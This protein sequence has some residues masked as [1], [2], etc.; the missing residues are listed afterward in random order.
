VS[1]VIRLTAAG[2]LLGGFLLLPPSVHAQAAALVSQSSSALR[3]PDALLERVIRVD[4]SDASIPDAADIIAGNAGARISYSRELLGNRRVSLHRRAITVGA[5]LAEILGDSGLEPSVS[6]GDFI[7]IEPR[8][9]ASSGL[10][11][12]LVVDEAGTPLDGASILVG[13]NVARVTDYGG[14]FSGLRLPAGTGVILVRKIGYVARAIPVPDDSSARI[15]LRIALAVAPLDLDRIVV[16]GALSGSAAQS[17][18]STVTVLSGT[19]LQAMQLRTIDDLFRGFVPGVVGWDDG[20]S[21]LTSNLGSVRG[22]ASFSVNYFKTYVDGVE[23][24]APFL[25]SMIDPST[26]DR[27]EIIRGPQGAALHGSD[28]SS[29]VIQIVTRDGRGSV[30]GRPHLEM[31]VGEGT[32]QSRFVP[33]APRTQELSGSMG[34]ANENASFLFGGKRQTTGEFVKGASAKQSSAYAKLH[35]GTGTANVD[36]EVQQND[37]DGGGAINPILAKIGI[38]ILHATDPVRVAHHRTAGGT[39]HLAPSSHVNFLATAGYDRSSLAGVGTPVPFISP[40]DSVLLASRGSAER[41]SIRLATDITLGAL[42]IVGSSLSLGFD[43]SRL[44]HASDALYNETRLVSPASVEFESSHGLFSQANLSLAE[45]VFLTAGLR[46]EWNSSFGTAYGST[47]LPLLGLSVVRDIG[48]VTLKTRSSY[49]K[50]IRPPPIDA[51]R[52]VQLTEVTQ[53]ANPLL[54]PESQSGT[55]LGLDAYFDKWASLKLTHYDQQAEGLIQQ[56]LVDGTSLPR[57]VQQQNIGTIRNAG[58]ELEA[59]G[60]IGWLGLLAN[61]ARTESRVRSIAP[62][63]T[64]TLR[65]GDRMLEVPSWTAS[66]TTTAGSSDRSLSLTVWRVGD[67]INYDWISL[68]TAVLKQ[69]PNRGPPRSYWIRYP[70]FTQIRASARKKIWRSSEMFIRGDNLSNVQNAGRDNLHVNTGRTLTLGVNA[71]Y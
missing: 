26:V 54:A 42:G 44:K 12:G 11:S 13:G 62:R 36:L 15:H 24:A 9:N 65:P 43:A 38:P 50:G 17:L 8:S 34:G 49:G 45:T 18:P 27:I 47:Q 14:L 23:V 40:A 16:M 29:G 64:G 37:V 3:E 33:S 56:V 19:M 1:L 53:R 22:A 66:G 68:Y 28:A 63:Y 6:S 31:S 41:K 7:I 60:D 58:W 46:E 61:Y 35:A 21:A 32:M 70:G 51:D 69:D 55:E 39:L 20:P 71:Q 48:P 2:V 25:G 30:T 10:L 4:V 67:W 59:N 52:Q 5:A 57:V